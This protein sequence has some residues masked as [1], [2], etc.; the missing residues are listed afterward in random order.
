MGINFFKNQEGSIISDYFRLLKD[1]GQYTAKNMVQVA[2]YEDHLTLSIPAVKQLPPITLN[3]SQI[4]QVDYEPYVTKTQV[5][6]S[7]LNRTI[8]GALMFGK[9]G[10]MLGMM[11]HPGMKTKS[12]THYLFVIHYIPA[13]ADDTV[14]KIMNSVTSETD[15][16]GIN[17]AGKRLKKIIAEIGFEDTRMYKGRK[18]AKKLKEL[19][20]L[21]KPNVITQL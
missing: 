11:S 19:C 4:L 20:G 6:K 10:A 9:Q 5:E 21:P 12:K 13:G 15:L 14:A 17:R 8:D 16:E 2:L 3:Y 7:R 18:L 1:V